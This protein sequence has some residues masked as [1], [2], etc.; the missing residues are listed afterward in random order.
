M[1]LREIID[2]MRHN[3]QLYGRIAFHIIANTAINNSD[4]LT[5]DITGLGFAKQ[6]IEK[7]ISIYK[8]F[9]DSSTPETGGLWSLKAIQQKYP[10]DSQNYY[11]ALT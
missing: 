5:N 3:P 2:N 4:A 7:I 11:S 9:F 1:T 6:D 10:H 8:G